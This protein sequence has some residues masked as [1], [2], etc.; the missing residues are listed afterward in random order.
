MRALVVQRIE[1]RPP[2]LEMQVRFPP[3]APKI[4][5]NLLLN[6]IILILGVV[7]AILLTKLDAE[8]GIVSF[9]SSLSM[10]IGGTILLSGLSLRFWAVSL[11]HNRNMRVIAIGRPQPFLLKV[12]PY[13]FSRNPL[14]L[15]IGSIALGFGL[16]FGSISATIFAILVF[17][18]WDL[19]IR[20]FE[21][22]ILERVFGAEYILYKNEVPR[23]LKIG[24]IKI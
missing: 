24:F 15:G 4:M 3:R 2:K 21:E 6:G 11:F 8:L 12:G 17:I 1:C 14:Y 16:I 22:K 13:T 10:L 19:Y 23:W 20:L 7:V 18:G 9:R 5:K